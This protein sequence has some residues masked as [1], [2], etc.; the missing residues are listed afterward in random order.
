MREYL[1]RYDQI[2][3]AHRDTKEYA[4]V[5][6]AR[7]KTTKTKMGGVTY[8][9]AYYRKKSGGYVFLL[10]EAMGIESGCGLV[11]ENLAEQIVVECTEKSFR[12]AADTISHLTGQT[13]SAMGVWNVLQQYG[14]KVEAREKR[15]QELDFC[16]V[17]GQL[18]NVESRVIPPGG[19]D[20]LPSKRQVL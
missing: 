15:L 2:L 11:S 13:I 1:Q 18:D 9:R 17:T 16:G 4:L 5:D 12:K 7:E 14:E 10:D 3:K 8:Q 6:P 20:G 19:A